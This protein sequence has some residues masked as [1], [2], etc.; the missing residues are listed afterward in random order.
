[1]R[2]VLALVAGVEDLRAALLQVEDLLEAKRGQWTFLVVLDGV[3]DPHNLGAC[4]RVADAGMYVSK[5]A[6][7]NRVSTAEEY[8]EGDEG[9]DEDPELDP[10]ELEEDFEDLE[11]DDEF[12]EGELEGDD[13]EPDADD[14][15]AAAASTRRRASEEKSTSAER[16]ASGPG[17]RS[18]GRTRSPASGMN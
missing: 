10:E 16:K 6:G 17:G 2:R 11:E 9:A 5:H 18:R 1:M 13:E 14:D 8:A 3:E 12:S 7:G 15:G 4:L